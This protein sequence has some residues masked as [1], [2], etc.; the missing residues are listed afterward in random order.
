MTWSA[1]APPEPDIDT[2]AVEDLYRQLLKALG[3]DPDSAELR[4]TPRRAAAFWLE[5]LNPGG[6]E[7]WTCFPYS[8]STGDLVA[9]S[10]IEAWTVCQ[11]HLLPFHIT[12][13][14]AYVPNGKILGLSK[15]ARIVAFHAGRLQVQE[16]LTQQVARSLQEATDSPAVGVWVHGEHLCMMMRGA[17]ADGTRTVTQTLLGSAGTD[18]QLEQRM[19]AAAHPSVGARW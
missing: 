3:Q 8:Q 12:A 10:G 6:Q 1:S 18:A 13:A 16:T 2:A 7:S 4:D 14:A 17:R 5:F 15:I 19:Y 11:H 9:V